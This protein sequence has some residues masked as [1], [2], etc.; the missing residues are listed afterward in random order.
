MQIE[1]DFIE[2]IINEILRKDS[3]IVSEMERIFCFCFC[4]SNLKGI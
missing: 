4:V 2:K 3:T 1:I